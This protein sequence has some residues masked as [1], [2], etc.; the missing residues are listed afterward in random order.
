MDSSKIVIIRAARDMARADGR[1]HKNE[2]KILRL[3]A[4]AEQLSPAEKSAL[5]ATS[6][7]VPLDQITTL[8]PSAADRLRLF[9]L[10]VLVGLA[11]GIE[12]ADEMDRLRTIRGT[13]GLTENEV[14]GA[15]ERARERFFELTRVWEDEP[16]D[17][18]LGPSGA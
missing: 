18:G 15:L 9:E 1:L 2:R 3:I 10:N 11:D 8:L 7:P 16:D 6:A 4:T 5:V 12:S 13:L 14:A 17:D